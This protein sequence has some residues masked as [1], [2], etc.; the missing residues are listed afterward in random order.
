MSISL[1]FNGH[2]KK[3][4]T[5]IPAKV[6]QTKKAFTA[7]RVKVLLTTMVANKAESQELRSD[8]LVVKATPL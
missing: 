2:S 6:F 7:N 3:T 4:F 8:D 1:S 5:V